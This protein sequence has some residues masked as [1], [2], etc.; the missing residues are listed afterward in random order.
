MISRPFYSLAT[1]LSVVLLS[2]CA[3]TLPDGGRLDRFTD[4]I[5]GYDT[6][7]TRSEKEA[8]IS[9]LQGDK[10][11]QQAQIEEADGAPKAN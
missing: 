6:T 10:E 9:E 4:V 5:R 8:A 7:L 11:R 3:D 2:G 1:A